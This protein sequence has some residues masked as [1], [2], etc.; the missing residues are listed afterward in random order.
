MGHICNDFGNFSVETRRESFYIH[1][2]YGTELRP[3][4]IELS[5]LLPG[6]HFIDAKDKVCIVDALMTE[7]SEIRRGG[8]SLVVRHDGQLNPEGINP[9]VIPCRADGSF[10]LVAHAVD[11]PL[12]RL[13]AS[14]PHPEID[15]DDIP[16][17]ISAIAA[18]A[19]YKGQF[20][21]EELI[22]AIKKGYQS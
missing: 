22:K 21:E 15:L 11:H 2:G 9:I 20:P 12:A 16:D 14:N 7:T 6:R 19:A 10:E 17:L 3:P 8:T 4:T 5:K 18:G 1:A 13:W